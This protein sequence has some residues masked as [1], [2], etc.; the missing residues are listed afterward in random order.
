MSVAAVNDLALALYG[1]DGYRR[2]RDKPEVYGSQAASEQHDEVSYLAG[3]T[4]RGHSSAPQCHQ[5]RSHAALL[6]C[7]CAL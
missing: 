2:K 4:P 7:L 1:L 5:H 6:S 3:S